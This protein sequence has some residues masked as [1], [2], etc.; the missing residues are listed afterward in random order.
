MAHLHKCKCNDIYRKTRI[1]RVNKVFAWFLF[2]FCKH[3]VLPYS[4]RQKQ[5]KTVIGTVYITHPYVLV[6]IKTTAFPDWNDILFRFAVTCPK[7]RFSYIYIYLYMLNYFVFIDY[8]KYH[9]TREKHGK[10]TAYGLWKGRK[11]GF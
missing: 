4:H 1:I 9:S 7:K 2:C 10:R 5:R 3:H 6:F 8:H 11:G